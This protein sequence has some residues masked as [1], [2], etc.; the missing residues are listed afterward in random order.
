MATLVI[1]ASCSASGQLASDSLLNCRS[2][3]SS[4]NAINRSKPPTTLPT[5]PTLLP[6]KARFQIRPMLTSDSNAQ[7]ASQNTGNPTWPTIEVPA[8]LMRPSTRSYQPCSS[9][10][11]SAS[12][13]EAAAEGGAMTPARH[14]LTTWADCNAPASTS[15]LAALL[16]STAVHSELGE[17]RSTKSDTTKPMMPVA[18]VRYVSRE[19]RVD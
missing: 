14:W 3:T 11:S 7:P 10:L 17:K 19:R 8:P 2:S 18:P 13:S 4:A 16:V 6:A 1:C 12:S 5:R 9:P 15:R